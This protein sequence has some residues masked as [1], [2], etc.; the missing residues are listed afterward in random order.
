MQNYHDATGY[1]I[2]LRDQVNQAWF[3]ALIDMALQSSGQPPNPEQLENLWK[4]FHGLKNYHPVASIPSPIAPIPCSSSSPIFLDEL[5]G[6]SGFKKL[7][8]GLELKFQKQVSLIFGKNG[9][10]KSSVCQA[11]KVLAN[12]EKPKEPLYNARSQNPNDPSFSYSF[13]GSTCASRWTEAIGYGSQ[14]HSIKYFDSTIAYRHATGEVRPEEAVEISVFRL[15]TFEY[16]RALVQAFQTYSVQKFN[17]ERQCLQ[18]RIDVLKVQLCQFKA[19]D[20]SF[21]SGWTPEN[22]GEIHAWI[23]TLPTFDSEMERSLIEKS[24]RLTQM[25][26]AMS[27]EGLL[28]LRAQHALIDQLERKLSELNQIGIATPLVTLQGLENELMQKK[29]AAIELSKGAFP[30]GVNPSKHQL[31]LNAVSP[32]IDFSNATAGQTKCPLCQQALGQQAERLF[33]A[34]HRFLTASVQTEINVL[35]EKL[36]KGVRNLCQIQAFVLADYS[37]CSQN[38]PKDFLKLLAQLLDSIQ[39]AIPKNG[40]PIQTIDS[41]RFANIANLEK[42]LNAVISARNG[43]ADTIAK[44]S[45][46]RGTLVKEVQALQVEIERL[47]LQKL[48][49]LKRDEML[50][51]CSEAQRFKLFDNRARSIDFTSLLRNMTIKGKEAHNALVL[52]TFGQLLNAEYL[53]LSGMSFAEMG[54]RLAS[55]GNQQDIIVTPQVGS[56]PVH[57]VLSEGEQKIHALAVFLCEAKM[58]PCQILVFDDPVNSFDYN[59]ISNFCE[60]LRDHIREYPNNQLIILTHNWDFFVNLQTTINRDAAIGNKLSVQ[61]IEDCSTVEEYSEKWDEL[62]EQINA[63]LQPPTEP[64]AEQKER[65]A[66]LLRRLIERLTNKFVFN[67]QRHQYKNKSLPVSEFHKF[68]KIVPLLP[69]EA[70]TLRDLYANLSP[71][72]HDD[73]RNY[74]TTKSKAQFQTWYNQVISI[75]DAIASRRP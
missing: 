69:Q 40:L 38:L 41:A 66:G 22:S 6:F 72:E 23:N 11:L 50:S 10:G 47:Q 70:D 29:A 34:Y 60:R 75:K 56:D 39:S 58:S 74:Y 63:I 68:T 46:N 59:Y 32:M 51:I 42:Y 33:H 2:E 17:S 24:Q 30:S 21:F 31:L 5:S 16:A 54:I 36:A 52:E 3:H 62:C 27:D 71:P 28:G 18:G 37:S 61:I 55:R 12:P 9:S 64:A 20:V 73:V 49:G 43:L 1:L 57:R 13:R 4:Y 26:T 48:V 45:D 67:E 35:N 7:S 15:E 53:S 19:L 65:I 25:N 14:A 44:S 8:P